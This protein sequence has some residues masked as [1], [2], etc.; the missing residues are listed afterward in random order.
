MIRQAVRKLLARQNPF[1][2]LAV[3]A[4]VVSR[5]YPRVALRRP[6]AALQY[7]LTDPEFANFTYEIGNIDE[8]CDFLS[9][10]LAA[11]LDLVQGYATELIQDIG[12][13]RR[14]AVRLSQRKDRKP[15]PLYGRRIGW[16]CAV[17][18]LKP[19]L[20]IETGVSDGLGAAVLLR[21]LQRN[22]EEG[23]PGRLVGIDIDPTSGWLLDA[24]LRQGYELVIEDS[25]LALP[26]VLKGQQLDL[27]IHD[28]NHTYEHEMREYELIESAL[29][30]N[31]VLLS[32]NAHAVSTL[33]DYAARRGRPY[34]FFHEQPLRHFYPGAGIGLSL[35]RVHSPKE[36]AE[37]SAC[38]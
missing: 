22:A 17:R 9:G 37:A 28:S 32:D 35:P 33:E 14:L 25:K 20:T 21:A 1:A 15:A 11:P 27:F 5:Y 8:L 31:A 24:E 12:L 36:L 7:I 10:H 18:I 4:Y 29:A 30:P 13:H 6:L 26:R 3:K 38:S 34:Y 19:R 16:Y 23:F 2:V